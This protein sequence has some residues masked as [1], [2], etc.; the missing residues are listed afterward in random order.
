MN[1]RQTIL[2]LAVT[3]AALTGCAPRVTFEPEQDHADYEA[4]DFIHLLAT[5]PMVTYGQG[6]RAVLLLADG[7]DSPGPF[8]ERHAELVTRGVVSERWNLSATDVLDRGTLAYMIF[9]TCGMPHSLNSWL[10]TF[11]GLGDRR[12]AVRIV[13]DAGIIRHGRPGEIPTGGE[14]VA[15]LAKADDYMA[16]HG[17]YE[18]DDIEV[19]SPSDV[20][21][22]EAGGP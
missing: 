2:V 20:D 3:L 21:G 11:T 10:S 6:C 1:S 8:E 15:A 19:T 12:Y 17:V 18:A 16:E 4:L 22:D 9:K 13:A 5:Q 7:E 14:V